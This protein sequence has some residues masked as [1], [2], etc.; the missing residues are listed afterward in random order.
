ML[1][2]VQVDRGRVRVS[3]SVSVSVSVIALGLVVC[4]MSLRE[5]TE[6]PMI[7]THI[8]GGELVFS[9]AFPT[10]S[11]NDKSKA[12]LRVRF[13]TSALGLSSPVRAR[14]LEAPTARCDSR[15]YPADANLRRLEPLAGVGRRA[16]DTLNGQPRGAK[17]C[18]PFPGIFPGF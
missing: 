5:V 1:Y 11:Q 9:A 10:P 3:V 16:R 12:L 15:G 7:I 8:L 14:P 18:C 13:D 2:V 6:K 17:Q 4:I